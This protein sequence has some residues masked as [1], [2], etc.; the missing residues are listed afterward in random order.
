MKRAITQSKKDIDDEEIKK[1]VDIKIR[2]IRESFE[3]KFEIQKKVKFYVK[4]SKNFI[5]LRNRFFVFFYLFFLG[6]Y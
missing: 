5:F 3:Q 2:N 4:K 6:N 1:Q